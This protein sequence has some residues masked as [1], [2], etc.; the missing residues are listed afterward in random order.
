MTV[1]KIASNRPVYKE[2]QQMIGGS[3]EHVLPKRL[4]HP[5]CMIVD[6]EGL[7]KKLP[8]NPFGSWLY[9]TDLHGQPIAGDILLMKDARIDG[10]YDIV[11]LSDEDTAFLTERF[12]KIKEAVLG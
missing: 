9:Q 11:G 4:P 12:L 1:T 5:Y 7:L 2:L 6:E 3:I 10:E 8:L